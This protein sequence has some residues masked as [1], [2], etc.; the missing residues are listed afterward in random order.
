MSKVELR[1]IDKYFGKF[2]AIQ[3]VDLT[4][5]KGELIVFVGPSG[6]G[7]STMLRLISG[8]EDIS[9]GELLIDEQIANNWMPVQRKVAMV[10]QSYALYPNM[11]VSQNIAFGL[12]QAKLPK[13]E[14]ATR[15][16]EASATL[17]LDELLGRRPS[18]LSGGQ[19][20]RV[21][22]GR[23]I[24]RDPSIFLF[25]EPLSNLDAELR[26]HMRVE[27]VALHQRIKKTMIYVTHDQVEAMT[28]AERIVVL[29]A[30]RIEQVGTP[31][32]LYNAPK[33]EFV[34]V[35]LGSPKMNI[36]TEI[37]RNGNEITL[38]GGRI[39]VSD[40]AMATH[41]V[42]I[43]VGLRPEHI[44][45]GNPE[46]MPL[47]GRVRLVEQLGSESFIYVELSPEQT[48]VVRK[49]GQ[50]APNPGEIVGAGHLPE[51]SYIFDAATGICMK[52]NDGNR[53]GYEKTHWKNQ[54]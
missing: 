32:E 25:D 43:K 51:C 20:Q 4:I 12:Q 33:N 13:A 26:V 8:L 54:P 45:L 36:L 31:L 6:C 53:G 15:V 30:G 34:A 50:D 11:T 42:K 52:S 40:E 38:P 49:S 7:K 28:M 24:V 29:N 18:Q 35:F 14:I 27:L 1:N 37:S 10:F 46:T 48:I 22:I 3:G 21:A 9:G 47:R 44:V 16:A 17:K 23:A 41:S 19:S 39:S 5:N 2:H